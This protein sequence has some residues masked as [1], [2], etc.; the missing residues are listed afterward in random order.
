[1]R[2][3]PATAAI[4]SMQ[5]LNQVCVITLIKEAVWPSLPSGAGGA[6][7]RVGSPAATRRAVADALAF[8]ERIAGLEATWRTKLG[9]VRKNSSTDLLLSAL[10]AAPVLTV[11]GAASLIGRSVQA[12]NEAVAGWKKPGCSTR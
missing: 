4:L 1:M 6:N 7:T 5:I 10:P 8:E 2:E 11:Q 3:Y 9:R 12:A